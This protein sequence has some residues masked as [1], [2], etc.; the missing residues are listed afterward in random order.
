MYKF[1][2]CKSIIVH[3]FSAGFANWTLILLFCPTNCLATQD[4]LCMIFF[5]TFS[6][7]ANKH[8]RNSLCFFSR[9]IFIIDRYANV[10]MH[11]SLPSVALTKVKTSSVTFCLKLPLTFFMITQ[12]YPCTVCFC[13]VL[14]VIFLS[15][16][17]HAWVTSGR[18]G[19]NSAWVWEKIVQLFV[20][21]IIH[22]YL[23]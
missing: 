15:Y 22:L 21:V 12:A 8:F 10:F 5:H 6:R 7:S 16:W 23:L 14:I 9:E 11:H 13:V 4:H 2:I 17:L 1:Q 20:V 3:H 18:Q 19:G